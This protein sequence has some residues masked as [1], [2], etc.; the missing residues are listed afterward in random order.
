MIY[1][2]NI[3][4]QN[5]I[6]INNKNNLPTRICPSVNKPTERGQDHKVVVVDDDDDIIIIVV[7][8]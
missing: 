4:N 2:I 8:M 7:N 6:I 5:I 1:N 3:H